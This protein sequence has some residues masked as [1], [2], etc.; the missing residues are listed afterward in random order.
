[1]LRIAAGEIE[2]APEHQL[3]APTLVRSEALAALY[4]AA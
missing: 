1:L 3:L 2:V 4:G